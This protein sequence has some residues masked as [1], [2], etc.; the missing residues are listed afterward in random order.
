MM[1]FDLQKVLDS[2]MAYRQKLAKLPVAEKMRMLDAMREQ[3]VALRKAGA[4]YLKKT[5]RTG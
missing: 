4:A 3:A 1:N 5:G 2:K